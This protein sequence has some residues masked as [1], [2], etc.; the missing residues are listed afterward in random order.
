MAIE[1]AKSDKI[2]ADAEAK[3][4]AEAEK[5]EAERIEKLNLE[6]APIKFQLQQ[7]VE[8]FELNIPTNLKNN[9]TANEILSKFWQFK[10]WSKK[11]I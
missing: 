8:N 9:E 10:S 5:L 2:I 7:W 11:Q 3:A 6:L 4:D 1:K